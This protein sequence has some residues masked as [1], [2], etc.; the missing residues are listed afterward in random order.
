MATAKEINIPIVITADGAKAVAGL[1]KFQR[2]GKK[3]EGF[4]SKFGSNQI[5]T[6]GGMLYGAMGIG[7]AIAGIRQLYDES[8]KL[9]E[10]AG[11]YSP[12]VI[13][14]QAGTTVAQINSDIGTSKAI[15]PI[16]VRR[17]NVATE[18]LANTN[19]SQEILIS[20]L[21]LQFDILLSAMGA[22]VKSLSSLLVG[23]FEGMNKYSQIRNERLEEA[24]GMAT[25]GLSTINFAAGA[26]Q[27]F[28]EDQGFIH[29][30]RMIEQNTKG[31]R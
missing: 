28:T 30:L 23:D 5:S 7:A 16:E 15:A 4:F 29:I 27:S 12:S 14:A 17:A 3:V 31:G 21:G 9:S 1:Q 24:G 6:L 13:Q 11:T 18:D 10:I 26:A 8:K 2:E 19:K 22:S 25:F 20:S